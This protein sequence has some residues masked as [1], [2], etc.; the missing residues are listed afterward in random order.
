M[1]IDTHIHLFDSKYREDLEEI[2]RKA[3]DIGVVKM[4][5]VGFDEESSRAA[6]ELSQ[7][8]D[9][10][11]AAV[12]LHPEEVKNNQ[13]GDLHW[14]KTMATAPKVVAIGEI[15]LDYYWDKTY[16]K[17]QIDYFQKQMVMAS[18]L[19]LPV[20]VHSRDASA[21]TL[22]ILKNRMGRGVLHCYSGSLE[23]AREFVKLG[24]YLGIG[25]VVTF[26]NSKEIKRVVTEIP[27]EH[28]LTETDGPYL[29][30]APYRGK[31]NKPEYLPLVIDAISELKGIDSKIVEKSLFENA[32]KLFNI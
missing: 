5:V 19:N 21:D 13:D 4:V 23:M 30:P 17:E 16:Q 9:F 15:G 2:I 25:G 6:I 29:A 1:I 14:L 32:I 24:Y 12:G 20:L 31:L 11:F 26:K 10:L 7:R 28:L 27:L 22:E 18:D 8:F 3:L